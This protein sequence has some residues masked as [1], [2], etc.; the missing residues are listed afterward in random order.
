M[1][2]GHSGREGHQS[3]PVLRGSI[4]HLPPVTSVLLQAS[5]SYAPSS[6]PRFQTFQTE[7]PPP[8]PWGLRL[9]GAGKDRQ[10]VVG[11]LESFWENQS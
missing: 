9:Q 8:L 4:S 3:L 5:Q 10:F 6:P 11:E 1:W 2:R 7:P